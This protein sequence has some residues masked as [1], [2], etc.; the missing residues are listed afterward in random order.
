M[1]LKTKLFR[2]EE[3]KNIGIWIRVSTDFQVK[4]ES[5]EHHE[6]RARLYAEAKGWNIITIYRLDALSGKSIMDYPE[7]KRMLKDIKN[8]TITGIIFSKLARLARNTKELL[9]ISELF[10]ESNADL[11]S[12]AEAIDTSSP[13]GRLFFT[14]IAAMAQ[15]EREEIS[16]RVAASVPIRAQMGKSLGGAASFGYKWEGKEFV[17]DENEAPVRKLIYEIYIKTRRRKS[18]STQLNELGYRTRN[19]SFFSDTTVERL[20]RDSTAKG[21]R[22]ANYTQSKGEGKN[23][24]VKPESDWITMSCP[25]IVDETLW[26]MAN[27]IMDEQ[28]SKRV[29]PGP[30]AVHLLSGYVYCTCPNKM[31]VYTEQPVY[32]C[33]ICKC[34]IEVKDLDEIYHAQLK[35]FLLTDR[36]VD[37]VIS[38]SE[39]LIAEKEALLKTVS[40]EYDKLLQKAEQMTNMRI[41]GELTKEDFAKFYKPSETRLRQIENQMP[42]LQAEIDFLKIQQLSADTVIQDAKDLYT[43]WPNLPFEEKRS[44]IETI[45]EK[46]IINT[47]SIDISLAYAPA[48]TSFQ[49]TEKGHATMS[50]WLLQSSRAGMYLSARWCT[51]IFK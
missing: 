1:Y 15:W 24:V 36:D 12:L 21:I 7:T 35:S 46:I 39:T 25:A 50:L 26:N 17:I 16:A 43:N 27:A 28:Q 44:I 37:A 11:I 29:K 38:Q 8:G 20:I 5:P 3:Q 45:T 33:K 18:T 42:E 23:W 32:K 13:A 14:I 47:D 49:M 34:K 48:S 51:E 30:K 9:E 40:G 2:M 31:Y 19:G 4:D 41:G 22:R 10:R 6:K